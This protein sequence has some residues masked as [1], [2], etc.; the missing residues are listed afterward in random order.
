MWVTDENCDNRR[1]F[2]ILAGLVNAN[3]LRLSRYAAQR[4]SESDRP[5]FLVPMEMDG[6]T[7]YRLTLEINSLSRD[8][9]LQEKE[10]FD[11]RRSK[12]ISRQ[13]GD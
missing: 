13:Y 9:Q 5:F 3:G 4:S 12:M 8:V 7:M 1:I 6:R 10:I 11:M 2:E